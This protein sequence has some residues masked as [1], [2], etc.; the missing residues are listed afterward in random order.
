M[1]MEYVINSLLQFKKRFS[2]GS[3][4]YLYSCIVSLLLVHSLVFLIKKQR[5]AHI[6]LLRS[7]FASFMKMPGC[8]I[9]STERPA[10]HMHTCVY[11]LY[12][13]LSSLHL[14][15]FLLNFPV[16]ILN[17]RKTTAYDRKNALIKC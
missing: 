5:L 9:G 13:P 7:L 17:E 1:Y 6:I 4:T 16:F 8:Q 15:G 12:R 3:R 2:S 14:A 11:Y 10:L